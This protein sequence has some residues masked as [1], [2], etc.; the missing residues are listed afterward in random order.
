MSVGVSAKL[1]L[2]KS[3]RE[4]DAPYRDDAMATAPKCIQWSVVLHSNRCRLLPV[5][6]CASFIPP[7][8][9]MGAPGMASSQ[10]RNII[11][12]ASGST[13]GGTVCSVV[14]RVPHHLHDGTGR[15]AHRTENIF[16][17]RR[18]Y[19]PFG[20]GILCSHMAPDLPS[21]VHCDKDVDIVDSAPQKVQHAVIG[22]RVGGVIIIVVREWDKEQHHVYDHVEDKGNEQLVEG[23]RCFRPGSFVREMVELETSHQLANSNCNASVEQV[24]ETNKE[25]DEPHVFQCFVACCWR[26]SRRTPI[27][28]SPV[29]FLRFLCILLWMSS[30]DSPR[31]QQNP[32]SMWLWHGPLLKQARIPSFQAP[33]GTFWVGAAPGADKAA[34]VSGMGTANF[35]PSDTPPVGWEMTN[36]QCHQLSE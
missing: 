36:P 17:T 9:R 32:I 20:D 12:K 15:Q 23:T 14:G 1:L 3:F 21:V 25:R 5:L 8:T 31:E 24:K 7:T 16:A 26:W 2:S 18:E 6:S 13:A 34:A 19:R 11:R 28:P 4:P 22:R 10:I 35:S 30:T 33:T 27:L 29:S